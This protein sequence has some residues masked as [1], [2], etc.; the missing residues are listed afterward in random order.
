M[1]PAQGTYILL[2]AALNSTQLKNLNSQTEVSTSLWETLIKVSILSSSSK[3]SIN[4]HYFIIVWLSFCLF[5]HRNEKW[6]A[7]KILSSPSAY[8]SSTT[9]FY[10][11]REAG[12]KKTG[13]RKQ[14][15]KKSAPVLTTRRARCDHDFHDVREGSEVIHSLT[16]TRTNDEE[17][18]EGAKREWRG[19]LYWALNHS[20]QKSPCFVLALE[21]ILK[22]RVLRLL[23][24]DSLIFYLV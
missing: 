6:E 18:E 5:D 14:A 11:S 13:R 20:R 2:S 3:A 19:E 15:S 1:K 9:W 7:I 21:C 17:E 10:S 23:V 16:H 4:N 8:I 22:A 24:C 12:G